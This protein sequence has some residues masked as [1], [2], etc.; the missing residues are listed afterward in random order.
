[1][2]GGGLAKNK[3]SSVASNEDFLWWS[4]ARRIWSVK[5]VEIK[6]Q[7][8]GASR[9]PPWLQRAG[10]GLPQLP[11]PT[12]DENAIC[13]SQ[14]NAATTSSSLALA[15]FS[16]RNE[17]KCRRALMSTHNEAANELS[18]AVIS[19]IS[20]AA[21]DFALSI[22]SWAFSAMTELAAGPTRR[23][24]TPRQ[25][26]RRQTAPLQFHS[27]FVISP[28]KSVPTFQ[29]YL[30]QLNNNDL[31][32][33]EPLYKLLKLDWEELFSRSVASYATHS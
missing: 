13:P 12:G 18:V 33:F 11:R 2:G 26:G 23:N 30:K 20:K 25:D 10:K 15:N 22:H 4:S 9:Q 16:K 19:L 32:K 8:A 29:N 31:C 1:M 6:W 14:L 3:H 5:L 7:D 24:D 21:N 17:Q 28:L 27:F